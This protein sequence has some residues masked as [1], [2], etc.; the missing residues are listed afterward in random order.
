VFFQQLRETDNALIFHYDIISEGID[1][2]GITGVVI[3]RNMTLSKLLQT[4]GRAVRKYKAAPELKPQAWVTVTAIDGDIE[5]QKWIESVLTHIRAGGF[6]IENIKFTSMDG[7]GVDEDEGLEDQYGSA[8]K[9]TIQTTI[10]NIIHEIEDGLEWK[11]L[12][13]MTFAER[14]D[15]MAKNLRNQ[16]V[17]H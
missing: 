10:E 1:I 4:I 3:N 9:G 2:D 12:T 13:E 15:L 11:K 17:D 6:A 16:P 7:P 5:N 8:I 14:M